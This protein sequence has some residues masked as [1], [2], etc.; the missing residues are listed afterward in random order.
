MASTNKCLAQSNKSYTGGKATKKRVLR[1]RP[2]ERLPPLMLGAALERV[3]LEDRQTETK[4]PRPSSF[5]G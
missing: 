1:Y 3:G 2:L 4:W 5:H